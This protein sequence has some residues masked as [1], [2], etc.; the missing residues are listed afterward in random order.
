MHTKDNSPV[1]ETKAQ[2]PEA[3]DMLI[4]YR[5]A[6]DPGKITPKDDQGAPHP[7]IVAVN[8]G[9]IEVSWRFGFWPL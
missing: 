7:G 2:E 3:A 9:F 1:T 4:E 8:N 6:G 5:K